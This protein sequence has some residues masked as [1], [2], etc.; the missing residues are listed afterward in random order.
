MSRGTVAICETEE[1]AEAVVTAWPNAT[2]VALTPIVDAWREKNGRKDS[3]IEDLFDDRAVNLQGGKTIDCVESIVAEIDRLFQR[4]ASK[5]ECAAYLSFAG[6]FHYLNGIFDSLVLRSEQIAAVLAR[7]E[8]AVIVAFSTPVRQFCGITSLDRPPWG[9]TSSLLPHFARRA[10]IPVE[11]LDSP[12][13]DPSIFNPRRDANLPLLREPPGK[14]N[15]L[16][17]RLLAQ[18]K[19]AFQPV[20]ESVTDQ[21]SAAIANEVQPTLIASLFSDVIGEIYDAWRCNGGRVLQFGEA[22]PKSPDSRERSYASIGSLLFSDVESDERIGVLLSW[23]GVSFWPWLRDWFYHVCVVRYPQLI[24]WAERVRRILLVER[25]FSNAVIL[26]GGWVDEHHVLARISNEAKIPTVS[27]HYG[28]YLGYSIIP[29]HERYDFAECDYFIVGGVGA[30]ETFMNPAPQT[31]WNSA[32]KRARPVPTGLGW[33]V[34]THDA[35][36]DGARSF[37]PKLRIMVILNALVGDCRDLGYVFHPEISYWRFKRRVVERLLRDP[38]ISILIKPPLT[39][40]YP[41]MANPL[42][43]WIEKNPHSNID[44]L[45]DVPLAQ[46]LDRADAFILESPSTPLIVTAATDKPIFVYIDR[47]LYLFQDRAWN[48]LRRRA[49]I[50]ADNENDFMARLDELLH[51][52]ANWRTPRSRVFLNDYVTGGDDGSPTNRLSAFLLSLT[53]DSRSG[54]VAE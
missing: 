23:R 30:E 8:P 52:K 38:D 9:L 1:Q 25:R 16:L 21:G 33:V 26:A 39:T 6:H 50:L 44:I 49:S 31:H 13:A 10:G 5:L 51:T 14:C 7:L 32:V 29:K 34:N 40:R 20:Y 22:F 45:P 17:E 28:G 19:G 27:Y 42:M 24:E 37:T 4:R 12:R 46:C 54:V 43:N 48:A 15:M 47:S 36:V 2:I 53:S 3:T 11:F 18:V 41:Q 35:Q